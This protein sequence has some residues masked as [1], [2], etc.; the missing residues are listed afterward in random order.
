MD[1]G[2]QEEQSGTCFLL[3]T[4]IEVGREKVGSAVHENRQHRV[5]TRCDQAVLF[6]SSF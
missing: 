4:S 1:R 5:L 6:V 3:K 2:W